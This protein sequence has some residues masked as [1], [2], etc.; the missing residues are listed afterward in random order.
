MHVH[1]Y[2]LL[3]LLGASPAVLT[4]TIWSLARQQT[5]PWHPVAV[6]VVTTGVGAALLDARLL[7]RPRFHPVTGHALA[8]VDRWTPF[9]RDVLGGAPPSLRVHTPHRSDGTPLP[10]IRDTDDDARFADLCYDLVASRTRETEALPVIGSLAGGRKT[11][12][13]HLMTAFSLFA[14]PQDRLVHVLVNPPERER[15]PEFF[16]PIGEHGEDAR[17]DRIELLFPRLRSLPGTGLPAAAHEDPAR[18][19]RERLA[20]Q[21]T[22]APPARLTCRLAPR[23][24]GG[25]RLDLEDATGTLLETVP[26]RPTDAATLLV[27]A[28]ATIAHGDRV[29]NTALV[30]NAAIEA[31]RAAVVYHTGR[32]EAPAPWG[33]TD[34]LSKHVSRLNARL[35]AYPLAGAHLPVQTRPL[36][37][38][39]AYGWLSPL[40]PL[41]VHTHQA[42]TDAPGAD[43]GWPF[44]HLPLQ[45]RPPAA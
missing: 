34:D 1:P 27:L 4:E 28:E 19:V 36:P 40:P 25:C 2:R 42:G 32:L 44:E 9:C 39:T 31:R 21:G 5:P 29:P 37:D 45:T 13:A 35:R 11:M 23:A 14:R 43:A 26:L 6:D 38:A 12:S 7:G 20:V 17:L 22:P 8:P 10:D 24:A 15:D 33:T 16:Y 30:E 3:I 18:Y 41:R